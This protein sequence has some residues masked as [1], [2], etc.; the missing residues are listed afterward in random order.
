MFVPN[1]HKLESK[2]IEQLQINM[3]QCFEH[4]HYIKQHQKQIEQAVQSIYLSDGQRTISKDV[5]QGLYDKFVNNAPS[6]VIEME[7]KKQSDA[8]AKIK[9]L[10]EQLQKLS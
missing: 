2:I 6:V 1:I 10:E 5:D 9:A 7:R 4:L 8:E 3:D